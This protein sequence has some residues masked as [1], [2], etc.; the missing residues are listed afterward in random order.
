MLSTTLVWHHHNHRQWLLTPIQL[1]ESMC[2]WDHLRKYLLRYLVFVS[3]Q[4]DR[5]VDSTVVGGPVSTSNTVITVWN[6]DLNEYFL[7]F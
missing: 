5:G 2:V 6:L 4:G 7:L 1:Q 3:T